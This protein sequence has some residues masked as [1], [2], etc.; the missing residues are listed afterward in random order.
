MRDVL[1]IVPGI[2][3]SR[4]ER[5]GH[6]I[7]G[8]LSVASAL[9][10]PEA[11]L[12]LRGDGFAPEPDV[13]AVGLLGRLSQLPGLAKIDAYDRLVEQ[14]R[15]GFDLDATNYV[16][17]AYDWRLSCTINARLL[18]QR[19]DPVLDARRRS[20][21]EA[22][23]VFVCHSM[24]GLVV[25][26]FT[27]VLGGG[28]D[29]KEVVSFG[30]PFRGAVKALGVLSRGWPPSLPVIRS[31]FRR[32]AMTLPSIHELLPSYRA[33]IE[34]SERRAMATGDLD[35]DARSLELYQRACSFHTALDVAGPRPYGRTVI[36]GSLQPTA[37]FATRRDGRLHVL[38]RWEH[39]GVV[40]DERGDGT[41]PRQSVAPPE[42]PN[43]R[44]AMPVSQCHVGLPTA[45]SVFRVLYNV[46]TASPRAEQ[47]DERAKLGIAVPDLVMA[48]TEVEIGCEVVEGDPDVPVVV[49]V[50]NLDGHTLPRL[51]SPRLRDGK[52]VASI[53]GLPPGDY[54]VSLKP[55]DNMPDVQLVWDALTVVSPILESFRPLDQSA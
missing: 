18:A 39:D 34:G 55:P 29:T 19:I 4:L 11:A 27:D 40:L 5:D 7:W 24:G 35:S 45:D 12:Q 33:I 32:L 44:H 47:A 20:D 46:V 25:Q 23:L 41:V 49:L 53:G 6:P 17:F 48:G 51:K 22:G 10:D 50:E 43:D 14:L 1:V 13:T 37:Q 30:V 54:R 38:E 42:W 3:G 15:A 2:G 31:R 52:L 8:G 26:Q 9:I 36:V 21:P 28:A 16:E